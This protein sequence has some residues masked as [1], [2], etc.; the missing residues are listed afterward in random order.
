MT[1]KLGKVVTSQKGL[2]SIESHDAWVTCS[3]EIKKE[4]KNIISPL[5]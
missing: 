5:I 2:Q 1:I 3:C 4:I